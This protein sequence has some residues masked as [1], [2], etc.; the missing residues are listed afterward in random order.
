MNPLPNYPGSKEGS[1]VD[2]RLVS[3]MPPHRTYVEG[4]LGG[5]AL[6]RRKRPAALS[7]GIDLDPTVIAAWLPAATPGLT[8]TAALA[9]NDVAR[10]SALRCAGAPRRGRRYQL[11]TAGMAMVDRPS[12]PAAAVHPRHG[13]R[14]VMTASSAWPGPTSF[15]SSHRRR[16]CCRIQ[17][18]FFTLMRLT[19]GSRA[20][21][22]FTTWR[23]PTQCAMR[24]CCACFA[25]CPAW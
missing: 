6:L 2:K 15:A 13:W 8:L 14:V 4:F 12:P 18:R 5:G 23:W 17:K 3:L 11:A 21:G 22:S 10:A 16:R 24:G 1:G 19:F 25:P 9:G 7:I 20:P